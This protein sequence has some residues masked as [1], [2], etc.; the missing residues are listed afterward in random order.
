MVTLV[1]NKKGQTV[2]EYLLLS[3]A[4]AITGL[5][6]IR[7]TGDF[8]KTTIEGIRGRLGNIVRNGELSDSEKAPDQK[9]HP[10]R[11]ERFKSLHF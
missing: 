1:K 11:K 7:Q 6:I 8:T 10:A 5:I 3:A 4:A 2:V 9:G